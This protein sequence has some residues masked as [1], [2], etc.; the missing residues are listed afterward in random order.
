MVW[1]GCVFLRL[2]QRVKRNVL[3]SLLAFGFVLFGFVVDGLSAEDQAS[4][5]LLPDISSFNIPLP[6]VAISGNVGYTFQT[7]KSGDNDRT[8]RHLAN[9]TLIGQSYIWQPWFSTVN[10]FMTLSQNRSTEGNDTFNAGNITG[11]INVDFLPLSNYPTTLSYA[12]TDTSQ[13]TSDSSQWSTSETIGLGSKVRWDQT[14]NFSTNMDHSVSS[15]SD[16][17]DVTTSSISIGGDKVFTDNEV[18]VRVRYSTRDQSP[19]NETS[20]TATATSEAENQDTAALS[21]R[22]QYTP[23]ESVSYDSTSSFLLDTAETT[24]EQRDVTTMQATS[25]LRWTPEDSPMSVSVVWGGLSDTTE[26]NYTN[27]STVSGDT[28]SK[29]STYNGRVGLIYDFTDQ[30]TGDVSLNGTLR[31]VSTNS[32]AATDTDIEGNENDLSNAILVGGSANLNY[33]ALPETLWGGSWY[34]NAGGSVDAQ[35]GNT[36]AFANS[37]TI[38]GGQTFARGVVVPFLGNI[39]WSANQNASLEQSTSDGVVPNISHSTVASFQEMEGERWTLMSLSA[40]D[41]RA[42]GGEN[43]SSSQLFNMQIT[44]GLEPDINSSWNANITL[45]VSRQ[46]QGGG[47]GVWNSSSQGGIGYQRRNFLSV[48]AL[49]LDTRLNL[50][51]S[52][53]A[54]VSFQTAK[55]A[56]TD[57]VTWNRELTTTLKYTIGQIAVQGRLQFSQNQQKEISDIFVLSILR[58]F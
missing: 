51:S 43:Q 9:T 38:K 46:V 13:S 52:T 49:D 58:S 57:S 5:T 48:R 24:A 32:T 14:L 25:T 50:A 4:E 8:F 37:Q 20:S 21:I 2:C 42:L 27:D 39:D 17:A 40:A 22:H 28:S 30:L 55:D 23:W 31:D 56:E 3:P 26:T 19:G 45:Q 41:T 12:R 35:G 33:T 16:S 47:E 10:G 29:R 18:G 54:P 15:Q 7:L 53:F 6:P 44:K 34:W 11:E 36:D 1:A